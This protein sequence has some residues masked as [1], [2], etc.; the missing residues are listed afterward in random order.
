MSAEHAALAKQQYEALQKSPYVKMTQAEAD[1][2]DKRRLRI[3]ELCEF[4]GCSQIIPRLF[5]LFTVRESGFRFV[6]DFV[7]VNASKNIRL[8]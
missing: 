7:A 3:G 5:K 1:A 6:V 8:Q 4:L 2:Y